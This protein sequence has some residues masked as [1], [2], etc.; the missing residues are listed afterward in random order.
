[1]GGYFLKKNLKIK[2][3]KKL[4]R[5]TKKKKEKKYDFTSEKDDF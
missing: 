3:E 4:Q 5:I 2:K 1:L